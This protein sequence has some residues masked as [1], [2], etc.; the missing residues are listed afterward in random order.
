MVTRNGAWRIVS[1]TWSE[2][3]VNLF[4]FVKFIFAH[5]SLSPGVLSGLLLLDNVGFFQNLEKDFLVISSLVSAMSLLKNLEATFGSWFKFY[6]NCSI[7]QTNLHCIKVSP[8]WASDLPH[9]EY[10]AVS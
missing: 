6:K 1:R 7:V 9:Q 8:V 2:N 3:N 10:F 4:Y 5:L